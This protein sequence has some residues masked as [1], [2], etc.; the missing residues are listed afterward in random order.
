M[1]G[2]RMNSEK[3]ILIFVEGESDKIIVQ[4]IMADL[5]ETGRSNI[6]VTYGDLFTAKGV[7]QQNIKTRIADNIRKYC[8]KYYLKPEEDI[9]EVIQITDTDGCFV[10]GRFIRFDEDSVDFRYEDDGIF[11]NRPEKVAERNLLKSGNIHRVWNCGEIMNIPFRLYY[12]SCNIDHVFYG[13]RNMDDFD[14]IPAAKKMVRRIRRYPEKTREFLATYPI[15]LGMDYKT[16]WN[17]IFTGSESLNRHTNICYFM[18][19]LEK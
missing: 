11:S 2:R 5:D 19:H 8:S 10:D 1:Q 4:A 13:E 17:A 7:S 3:K 18:E 12:M 14:K 15:R 6:I 16:S 9:A